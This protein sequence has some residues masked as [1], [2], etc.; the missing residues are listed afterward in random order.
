MNNDLFKAA[1]LVSRSFFQRLL[2][3]YPDENAV[4]ELNNLLAT[5]PILQITRPGITAIERKYGIDLNEFSLNLEEFYAVYLNH[6]AADL[7]IS[8]TDEAILS[9]MQQIFLLDADKV[10]E[11]RSKIGELIYAKVL[12]AA[13][14][15]GRLTRGEQSAMTNFAKEMYLSPAFVA[16]TDERVK[17]DF[18][19]SI[20]S[21]IL[22]REQFSPDDERYLE[23][24]CV[25][26][27]V[28]LQLKNQEQWQLER[29]KIYWSLEHGPL[30][31]IQTD[32]SL[33]RDEQCYF[34]QQRVNWYELRSVRHTT[35]SIGYSARIKLAKGFYLKTSHHKPIAHTANEMKLIESGTLYLTNK[36]ILLTGN[37][38]TT[39][40]IRLNKV[41]NTIPSQNGIE[42]IKDSGKTPLLEIKKDADIFT[43]LLERLV[44]EQ[45]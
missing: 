28:R 1:P 25:Q 26:L 40:N 6:A 9:H 32:I 41:L 19:Q 5:T 39:K 23:T 2:K 31:S 15:K 8:A 43:L 18:I 30:K 20:V 3:Q 42:I 27:G 22:K 24:A 38:G 4:I 36:R 7:I 35:G 11:L 12:E 17:N 10:R 34:I 45:N 16:T 14:R 37:S 33:Q 29:L 13:I 44:A 21:D